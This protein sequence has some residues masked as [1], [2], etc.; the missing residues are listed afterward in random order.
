MKKYFKKKMDDN[1]PNLAKDTHLKIQE[2]E[3]N[4][5]RINPK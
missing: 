5:S 1:L 2:N 4:T 3:K